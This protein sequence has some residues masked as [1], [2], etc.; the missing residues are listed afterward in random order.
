[1]RQVA[2]GKRTKD[3]EYTFRLLDYGLRDCVI[4]LVC[5]CERTTVRVAIFIL[6]KAYGIASVVVLPR[7]DIATQ[8]LR[9]ND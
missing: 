1:M 2:S 9:Q 5:H 8:S 4:I 6:S 7:K 3:K